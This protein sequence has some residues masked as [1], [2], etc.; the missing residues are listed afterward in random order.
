[1]TT[2]YVRKTGLDA[3]NGTTIALAKLTIASAITASAVGDTI[4]IGVGTWAESIAASRTYLGVSRNDTVISAV[5]S[6]WN[7]LT[8][9]F[10]NIK[11]IHAGTNGIT[12]TS[13]TY[14]DATD[15]HSAVVYSGTY[16]FSSQLILVR[17]IL[18][19]STS[20]ATTGSLLNF[21]TATASSFDH[22]IV[23]GFAGNCFVRFAAGTLSITNTI[24]YHK[25][26]NSISQS[27]TAWTLEQ[28]NCLYSTGGVVNKPGGVTGTGTLYADPVFQNGAAGDFRLAATS[29]CIGK[30]HA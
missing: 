18:I 16:Y 4:D 14:T 30:G 23:Y 25:Q 7:A 27:A 28:Y 11:L 22:V 12:A 6:A 10:T 13:L 15:D 9:A 19:G 24:L 8:M 3:Q 2:Y 1:M 20:N 29:P 26:F 17:T 5:N 21:A